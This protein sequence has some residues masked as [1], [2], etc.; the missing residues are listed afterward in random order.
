M[1]V[2]SKLQLL[3]FVVL[4]AACQPNEQTQ[5]S[6][7]MPDA[8]L[9]ADIKI[10]D[11]SIRH[12]RR[13]D[14]TC[15]S[16]HSE[17]LALIGPIGPDAVEV[18]DRLLKKVSICET[19]TG[20]IRSTV[21]GLFSGGGRLIDGFKLGELFRQHGVHT[22]VRAGHCASSC[23]T[24]F[25]GGK[26]RQVD[27]GGQLLFHAPY[28]TEGISIDCSDR[29]QVDAL[30]EYYNKMLGSESGSHLLQ[31]TMSYCSATDGWTL[32]GDAAELFGI[33]NIT[34]SG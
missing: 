21:V 17:W 15:A 13:V 26:F 10:N 1:K 30:A 7:L 34:S 29:G 8:E 24:A 11:L 32:N 4:F 27:V 9:V 23:A 14:D 5:T 16:G 19:G 6:G 22:I 25:I 3:A 28:T 2:I 31:R 20:Q 12:F 33:A 18:V